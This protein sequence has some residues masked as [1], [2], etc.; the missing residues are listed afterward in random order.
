VASYVALMVITPL[1]TGNA[2]ENLM[3]Y[4]RHS[5]LVMMLAV[6]LAAWGLRH[7]RLLP[8]A[9]SWNA[10]PSLHLARSRF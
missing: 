6:P 2:F 8:L 9:G 4:V 1:L 3:E 7:R 5:A 10:S